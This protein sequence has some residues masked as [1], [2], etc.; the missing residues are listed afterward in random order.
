MIVVSFQL[1]VRAG[2][3]GGFILLL[4]GEGGRGGVR[5]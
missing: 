1:G 4:G 5:V 2:R 3:E